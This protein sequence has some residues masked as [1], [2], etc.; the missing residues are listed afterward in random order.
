MNFLGANVSC[1]CVCMLYQKGIPVTV[2]KCYFRIKMNSSIH[3]DLSHTFS[4]TTIPPYFF[5]EKWVIF[6]QWAAAE[7]A[8]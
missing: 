6:S 2:Q 4:V 8:P 7:V 5:I 3:F 1:V